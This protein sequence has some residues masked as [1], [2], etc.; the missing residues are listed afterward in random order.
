MKNNPGTLIHYGSRKYDPKRFRHIRNDWIKP[1][2]GLW[3]SPVDSNW[4]W[5]D[6]CTSE[7]FR[8][9]SFNK[10]FQFKLSDDARIFVVDS[11]EDME[12]IPIWIKPS[13]HLWY[14]NFEKLKMDWDAVWLT[15]AGHWSTRYTYP[16]TLNGWDCES[17]FVM[18]K[19]VITLI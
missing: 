12:R 18:N 2:G 3:A 4:G 5:K 13:H 11:P 16:K 8:T 15:E 17:I 14:F 1:R 6:W 19:K 10:S 7:D 9:G